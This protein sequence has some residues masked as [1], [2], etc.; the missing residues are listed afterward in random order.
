MGG[1]PWREVEGEIVALD[2]RTSSYFGV[3]KTG[4]VLW[5]TLQEGATRAEL[6]ARLTA[7]FG[8]DEATAAAD[9]DAFLVSLRERGLLEEGF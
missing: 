3:N 9:L 1:V 5:P 7:S 2:L 8:I 4:T 6:V